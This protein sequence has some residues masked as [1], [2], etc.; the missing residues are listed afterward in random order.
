MNKL[1]NFFLLL[2][3]VI[4]LYTIFS[5]GLEV[6]GKIGKSDNYENINNVAL[7]LS[8][9]YIAGLIFYFFISYLPHTQTK[10]N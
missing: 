4:C 2:V 3:T 10:K 6:I 9:S 1:I 8:Y 5:V 7:N